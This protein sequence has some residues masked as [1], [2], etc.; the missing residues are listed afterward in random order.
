M[1]LCDFDRIE[2]ICLDKRVEQWEELEKQ[3]SDRGALVNRFVVGKGSVL[4]KDQYDQIDE[5]EIPD[6]NIWD[7]RFTKNAY[8]C[9]MSH[10]KILEKAKADG[11][12]NILLLEDD[13]KLSDSFDKI[14]NDVSNQMIELNIC[15][16]WDTFSFGQ[17]ITWGNA[18]RVS[19]NILKLNGGVY[20]WHAIAINYTVYDELLSLPIIGPFDYLW[21]NY[22][23]PKFNCYGIWPSVALQK[24]GM[25]YVNGKVEDYSCYM[26][27]KGSNI[28]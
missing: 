10:R 13:C 11:V 8:F 6:D 28:I 5:D 7:N 12:K 16:K 14:I 1:N 23:Q 24:P 4:Q 19:K 20:C 15:D 22:I 9:H 18:T 27:N 26:N 25:S 2:C 21:A 3:F 17:N